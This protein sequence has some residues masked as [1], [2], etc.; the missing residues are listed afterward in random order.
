LA[1]Q[2]APD[3]HVYGKSFGELADFSF[4]SG[5]VRRAGGFAGRWFSIV[6]MMIII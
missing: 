3:K 2:A 5:S 4:G 6:Y 1:S